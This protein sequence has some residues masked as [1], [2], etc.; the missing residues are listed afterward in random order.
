MINT[1]HLTKQHDYINTLAR[2]DAPAAF[3]TPSKPTHTSHDRYPTCQAYNRT[4]P[5]TPSTPKVWSPRHEMPP[6]QRLLP[7]VALELPPLWQR[8]K[9]SQSA[10][11]PMLM[12]AQALE[13]ALE[14]LG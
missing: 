12:L 8:A 2:V 13:P 4:S 14:P 1:L 10:S 7:R 6:Q 11:R 3:K 9:Q 5:Q